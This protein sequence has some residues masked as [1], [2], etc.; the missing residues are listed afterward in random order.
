MMGLDPISII[1]GI[2]TNFATDIIKHYAQYLDNTWVGQRLKAIGLIEKTRDDHLREIVKESL[3]LY[4]QTRP[5]YDLSGVE[6]F[7]RDPVTIQQIGNYIFDQLPLD[8]HAIEDALTRTIKKDAISMILMKRHG[9]IPEQIIPDFFSCYRQVLNRHVDA[10][11]KAILLAVLDATEVIITSSHKD[12]LQTQAI[13]QE[14]ASSQTQMLQGNP[15][16][17]A[18][19]QLI[20]CYRIEK[21]LTKGTFGT[22]YRAEQ[23]N[24]GKLVAL[25]V[26]RVP[27]SVS[28]HDDVFSLGKALLN[29]YHPAIVPTIDMHLDDTPPYIVS[30]YIE[31]EMLQKRIESYI[32]HPLPFDEAINILT[33]IGQALSYLHRQEIIHRGIQPKTILIDKDDKFLLTGFDLAIMAN[34]TDHRLLPQQPGTQNYMAPEQFRGSVSKKSD[35]YAL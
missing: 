35:Q 31:G 16:I 23:Q 22:L 28:L 30:E 21:Y 27:K 5:D 3:Q 26:I 11:E 33:Q 18:P 14:T 15:I 34:S 6:T 7:F 32:P 19:G 12:A 13:I 24:I 29:L 25:K 9:G 10:P 17:L 1:A 20:G 4:L 8:Q 2:A